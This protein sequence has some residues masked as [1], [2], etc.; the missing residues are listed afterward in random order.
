M[1]KR[2]SYLNRKMNTMCDSMLAQNQKIAK[3]EWERDIAT[4]AGFK[5]TARAIFDE[6]S[7][8]VNQDTLS[9]AD[10][11]LVLVMDSPCSSKSARSPRSLRRDKLRGR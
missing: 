8:V 1:R 7:M 10:R 6:F 9:L 3:L 11:L 4:T 2:M 5:I